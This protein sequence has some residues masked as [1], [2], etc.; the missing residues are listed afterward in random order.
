MHNFEQLATIWTVLLSKGH[1][2][3]QSQYY[4]REQV[5]ESRNCLILRH[6]TDFIA[7]NCLSFKNKLLIVFDRLTKRPTTIISISFTSTVSLLHLFRFVLQ[8]YHMSCL[9]CYSHSPCPWRS[10]EIFSFQTFC[11][12]SEW[13]WHFHLTGNLCGWVSPGPS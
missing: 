5:Q 6:K 9:Q 1:S 8:I 13:R 2:I 10:C 7:T 4:K 12:S 3:S 11:Y